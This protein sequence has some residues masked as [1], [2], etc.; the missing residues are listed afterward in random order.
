VHILLVDDDEVDRLA[1]LRALR[2]A[3]VDATLEEADSVS[4]AAMALKE[5]SFDCVLADYQLSP[6]DGLDVLERVRQAGLEIPVV[7]LTGQ[8]S[9]QTAVE[10]MKAGATDYLP[11]ST[12]SGERLAQSLRYATERRKLE[13]ERDRLQVRE[14]EA[15]EEAE[16]ANAAKDQFLAMLSH[17]LRQ[18]LNAIL[19]WAKMVR[20]GRLNRERLQRGLAV[21]ERNAQLQ[22]QLINDLLDVSRIVAGKLEL[23]LDSIDPVKICQAAIDV[24]RPQMAEKHIAIDETLDDQIG[25]I[26]ADAARLQQV[27]WN[28]LSNAIKF[29][30]VGGVIEFKAFRADSTVEI[31]VIDHGCGI[32]P[33]FLPHVFDRFSQAKGKITPGQSGLG[34]GLAIVRHLVE[35]HGGTVRA[36]SDGDGAGARFVVRLPIEAACAARVEHAPVRVSTEPVER[37]DNI[38]VVF[39]DDNAD[40]RELVEMMLADRGASVVTCASKDD[41]LALLHRDRPDVLISDIEM[42]DGDGYDLIRALRLRD[43][44][45]IAPI[46]A[47]AVTGMTRVE[48]RIRILTA[49]FQ[50]H[51]PKPIDAAELVTTIAVVTGQRRVPKHNAGRMDGSSTST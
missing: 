3:G 42:P 17:E 1:V 38:K 11:K 43:E 50:A 8:G 23:H 47:I 51:V 15:R 6:G 45:T 9:E 34:L 40:A 13:Q 29:S 7:I 41:A 22:V 14:R 19:G 21:I 20:D 33:D 24:L 5:R 12:L 46:P 10:L 36:D 4:A 48:D 32:Q 35:A 39:V 27:V 30:P 18:P 16:R 37:I 26:Q 44:D 31:A 25:P 49:G 2:A 28:L